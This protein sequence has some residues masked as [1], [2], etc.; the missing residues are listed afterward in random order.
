EAAAEGDEQNEKYDEPDHFIK[1]GAAV[2]NAREMLGKKS[3]VVNLLENL[4]EHSILEPKAFLLKLQEAANNDGHSLCTFGG[5]VGIITSTMEWL[6]ISSCETWAEA[7]YDIFWEGNA[8]EGFV[9]WFSNTLGFVMVMAP[10]YMAANGILTALDLS[11]LHLTES[12]IR[13]ARAG[14]V[15]PYT[16]A[17]GAGISGHFTWMKGQDL[18]VSVRQWR[19]K[20]PQAARLA[21]LSRL[22][23]L[24][25]RFDQMNMLLDGSK[26]SVM[27]E[28][29]TDLDTKGAG[30]SFLANRAKGYLEVMRE[31][32]RAKIQYLARKMRASGDINFTHAIKGGELDPTEIQ[33]IVD[34]VH[35]IFRREVGIENA[36][37]I[38]PEEVWKARTDPKSPHGGP[39]GWERFTSK[40]VDEMLMQRGIKPGS[41]EA[42]KYMEAWD[43]AIS[44]QLAEGKF[45]P[46][47]ALEVEGVIIRPRLQYDP[48]SG[49]AIYRGLRV[50]IPADKAPTSEALKSFEAWEALRKQVGEQWTTQAAIVTEPEL[51][52]NRKAGKFEFK[53][54]GEPFEPLTG[55]SMT[56]LKTRYTE[57]LEASG[58]KAPTGYAAAIVKHMSWIQGA[59]VILG[60]AGVAYMIYQIEF[61]PNLDRREVITEQ[62]AILASAI[63][64]IAVFEK[65]LGKRMTPTSPAMAWMHL[66]GVVVAGIFG[67]YL[68]EDKIEEI[69]NIVLPE[70]PGMHAHSQEL[71]EILWKQTGRKLVL[72][73][74]GQM[75]QR[76]ATQTVL[77]KGVIEGAE[78]LGKKA[79]TR[80][81]ERLVAKKGMQGVLRRSLGRIIARKTVQRIIIAA[82]G[83]K[84]AAAIIAGFADDA[85]AP[86]GVYA[87]IAL[88][89]DVLAV[90]AIIWSAWDIYEI[91][92]I[93]DYAQKLEEE[94]PQRESTNIKDGSIRVTN[95]AARLSIM[96]RL[97]DLDA[98][99]TNLNE[100]NL[101]DFVS[102][103]PMVEIAFQREGMDKGNIDE[104]DC[105]KEVWRFEDGIA[106]YV[107]IYKAGELY[108]EIEGL[109]AE[110]LEQA[111]EEGA[112]DEEEFERALA[113][114]ED[115]PT[116]GDDDD[117]ESQDPPK[118]AEIEYTPESNG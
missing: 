112:D 76:K 5:T 87:P 101:F 23:H 18:I 14:V 62:V 105:D 48:A 89:T 91:I 103:E 108:A 90:G 110:M 81:I 26:R 104:K 3:E 83:P 118:E 39:E 4:D 53:I 80:Q 42:T 86:T 69:L 116:G 51:T 84:K 111:A 58:T 63:A 11:K 102:S 41:R 78:S 15:M 71:G 57:A 96:T 2:E 55:E 59:E 70:Y 8:K 32:Y 47:V 13:G 97:G 52:Y 100:E 98:D 21:R 95:K 79:G 114:E 27:S 65:T 93:Y 19:A 43:Q 64:G 20:N 31:H 10:T 82:V 40:Q 94:L 16:L 9:N 67:V 66:F 29:I 1:N 117:P 37:N 49:R 7:A 35:E 109:D 38:S 115:E 74:L 85:L 75:A 12:G 46:F 28:H 99:I 61:N 36:E 24:C 6:T 25:R 60:T 113:E 54:N 22:E 92:K 33:P 88:L 72:R 50:E 68:G 56:E 34:E 73:P 77:R 106:T 17:K 30:K 107:A 45:D 44:K